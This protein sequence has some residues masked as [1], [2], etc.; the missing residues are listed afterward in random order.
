MS[1]PGSIWSIRA[2]NFHLATRS[3]ADRQ[4]EA[5]QLYNRSDKI[6]TKADTRRI[7]YL[8]GAIKSPQH[9]FPFLFSDAAA[10]IGDANHGVAAVTEQLDAHHAAFRRKFNR[11]VD[12]IG[13]RLD[14]QVTV[15]AHG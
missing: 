10:G 7:S 6:E 14:Q 12:Q 9:G 8:V 5:V 2:G 11:V 1:Q 3:G 13:N 4:A 15:A